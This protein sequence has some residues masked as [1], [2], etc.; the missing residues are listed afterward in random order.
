M[1]DLREARLT[2]DC[3]GSTVTLAAS[4]APGRAAATSALLEL[5]RSRMLAIHDALTRFEA[6]S[7]LCALNAD[8]RPVVPAPPLVR[9]L[10]TAAIAAGH[11]SDGLVDATILPDLEAAG[12]DS[13]HDRWPAPRVPAPGPR[14]PA[15]AGAGWRALAVDERAGTVTRPPGL[16]VDGGGLAK[17]MAADLVANALS[18]LPSYLVDCGGDLRTGGT[19]GLGR[20]V[21]VSDPIADGVLQRFVLHGGGLATTGVTRRRLDDD[22]LRHHLI[23]PATGRPCATGVLQASAIAP[24]AL[25]AEVRAKCAVLAGPA[26]AARWLPDGGCVVTEHGVIEVLAARGVAA[27]PAAAAVPVAEPRRSL[28]FAA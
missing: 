12:Y 13:S 28:A 10:V 5:S 7:A 24:T 11:D 19:A 16:R 2:F 23:D 26:G 14:R 6:S 9:A 3:F 25:Q 18:A 15:G 20:P 8:P 21:D 22:G 17:G 27:R 4:S 1:P